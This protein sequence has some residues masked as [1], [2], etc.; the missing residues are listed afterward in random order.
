M[1]GSLGSA[2]E[3]V[4]ERTFAPDEIE[5][6]LVSVPAAGV[7]LVLEPAELKRAPRSEYEG[8]FSLQYS[9]ASQLVRGHVS[10][11]DFT[12]EAI[13]DPE[14]LE[15]AAKVRYET[16]DYPTY[17]QAF[18]GGVTV[19]LADGTELE[20]DHAHQK[21]GPENPLTPAEVCEKFRENAS[22]VLPDDA[23]AALEE[24]VLS[25]EE[26]AD[27]TAALAPLQLLQ[28]VRA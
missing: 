7:S 16:R 11:P 10:V 15:V 2:A 22:L 14:V 18:P 5:D 20:A 28:A 8:K 21:G 19:R 13:A 12:E 4:G 6:V 26:Q 1:H 17:P 9:V 24:A 25:L 27:V 23:V 3:A